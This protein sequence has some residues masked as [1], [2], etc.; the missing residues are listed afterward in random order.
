MSGNSWLAQD[1]ADILDVPL[2]RPTDV[3][4]TARGA[5]MLAAV[6]A[7]FHASLKEAKAMLPPTKS[8]RPKMSAAIREARLTAWRAVLPTG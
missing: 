7:G 8:F 3:E 5:A 2:E 6:G 1:L 4:T